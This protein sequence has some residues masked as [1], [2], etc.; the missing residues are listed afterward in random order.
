MTGA[1]LKKKLIAMYGKD[2]HAVVAEECDVDKSTVY[3][4]CS[5][6]VVRGP[7]VAWIAEKLR[8]AQE[9]KTADQR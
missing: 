6:D 1:A 7:V 5:S 9:P 8:R 2:F 4:W 3:R